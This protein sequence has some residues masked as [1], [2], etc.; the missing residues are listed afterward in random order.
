[1]YKEIFLEMG[2][3]EVIRPEKE[4]GDK[5][6]RNLMRHHIRDVFDLDDQFAVIEFFPPKKWIGKTL[7]ELDLRREYEINIVGIRENLNGKMMVS[8]DP[9]MKIQSDNVMI[10]IGESDKFEHLDY[11]NQLG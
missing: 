5:V 4:M 3:S 8:I 10:A 9:N 11:T 2:A 6:G 7:Q 1:M